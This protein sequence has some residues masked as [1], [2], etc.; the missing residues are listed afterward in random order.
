MLLQPFS[1]DGQALT[2]EA[3]MRRHINGTAARHTVHARSPRSR[4]GSGRD[5][6]Y[7]SGIRP[8]ADGLKYFFKYFIDWQT[9]NSDA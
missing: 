7:S 3:K 9:S 2:E 8:A 1:D 4:G 6:G 5:Y